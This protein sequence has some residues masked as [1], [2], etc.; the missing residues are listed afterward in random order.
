MNNTSSTTAPVKLSQRW[1][2]ASRQAISFLMQQGVENPDCLSLAAGLV[3]PESLPVELVRNLSRELLDDPVWTRHALQY[4]TTAG[5]E[6][7]RHQLLHHFAHM[8]Q[9]GVSDLGIDPDR[10][11]A[12]TG[13]QQMLSVV[14]EVLMDPGDIC[15]VAAPTYFVFLGVLNGLGSTTITVDTDADGMIPEK[16]EATLAQ[17]DREGQLPR[18][19]MLYLVSYFE[20]PSGISVSEERRG[21]LLEIIRRYSTSHQIY[22]LE[23]TAYRELRYDGPAIPSVWSM[24]E[25]R[26]QV[27]VAQTF[28]KSFS[29]GLRVGYGVLPEALVGPVCDRKGNE[30]FGS[31]HLNQQILAAAMSRDLYRPHVE[32]VQ[33]AY[34]VKRDAMLEAADKYFSDIEGVSWV[35]PHGGL[36]VW[37]T[38]PESVETGFESALFHSATSSHKVMYVP[39]E[40]CFAGEPEDVPRNH[41][42]LSFGV[43]DVEGIDLA[44]KRL[45]EAVREMLNG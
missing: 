22:I 19:K 36:Y 15:L 41:M 25:T 11:V 31:A 28:S 14:G 8:E 13:S 33:N 23:D 39:G 7:L 29:P 1:R 17:L 30:D 3:D 35:R 12:T 27:I 44:M 6:R 34:R 4:G 40:L 9:C 43:Q 38:L 20:N 5:A 10:I 45:A 21:Q 32:K 42:R 18:V 26:E 2:W 16:L 24:D 37:M